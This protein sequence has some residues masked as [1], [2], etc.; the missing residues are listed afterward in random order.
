[1]DE[2]VDCAVAGKQNCM[3]GGMNPELLAHRP[4]VIKRLSLLL[5]IQVK[6]KD[7]AQLPPLSPSIWKALADL[8][9]IRVLHNLNG[10]DLFWVRGSNEWK[11]SCFY[12]EIKTYD[13]AVQPNLAHLTRA[14]R[15]LSSRNSQ[16]MTLVGAP[17]Y[18]AH[19]ELV[20]VTRFIYFVEDLARS[21]KSKFRSATNRGVAQVV[22]GAALL[23][24]NPGSNPSGSGAGEFALFLFLLGPPCAVSLSPPR[25]LTCSLGLAGCSVGRGISRGAQSNSRRKKEKESSLLPGYMEEGDEY[26]RWDE[27]IPDALGLIFRNLSLQEILT[28]V[29]RVCKSWSRAVSGPYCWQEINIEEWS[30][31][32]HPDHLDRML[33]MLITR[34]CGS[35]RKLCVSGLH[36][37]TNFSFLADQ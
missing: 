15:L 32:C 9:S 23:P 7:T 25:C 35:L 29:P 27:L 24:L 1:M 26:R 14:F 37:D 22:K 28:M 10:S 30:T 4:Q 3:A 5:P 12:V 17:L 19:L 21:L 18:R 11:D 33:Q 16:D 6:S 31:R 2:G 20:I 34:S 8:L 13:V 36:N